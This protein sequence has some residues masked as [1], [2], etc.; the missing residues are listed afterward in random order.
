MIQNLTF[1]WIVASVDGGVF[2]GTGI[3]KP[4]VTKQASILQSID[5]EWIAVGES[6]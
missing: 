3:E 5:F 6:S 1:T 2:G 4:P